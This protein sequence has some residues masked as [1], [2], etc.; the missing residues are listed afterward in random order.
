MISLPH[1]FFVDDVLEFRI[2]QGNLGHALGFAD[3]LA[4][5]AAVGVVVY[6]PVTVF[7]EEG[8]HGNSVKTSAT[9][10]TPSDYIRQVSSC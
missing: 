10:R 2:G 7:F 8:L 1:A 5:T 4:D 9:L 3:L 6:L